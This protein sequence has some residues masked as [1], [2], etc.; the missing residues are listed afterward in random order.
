VPELE[1]LVPRS[2]IMIASFNEDEFQRGRRIIAE[3]MADSVVYVL[4]DDDCL[5]GQ[6]HGPHWLEKGVG[7]LGEHK[8]FA[9]LTPMPDHGNITAWTGEDGAPDGYVPMHTDRVMEH[10]NVGGIRFTIKGL[11]GPESESWLP[12][13]P[14]TPN[15]YDREHAQMY[16]EQELRV[17]Y[18]KELT[19]THL[20]EVGRE[21]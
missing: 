4:A 19:F 16:H 21:G 12:Q 5:P 1:K 17:G 2:A 8:D 9:I 11:I 7:I 13:N 14:D 10:H 3:V 20:G 6:E 15:K 18:M